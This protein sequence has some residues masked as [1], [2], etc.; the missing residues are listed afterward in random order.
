MLSS[1]TELHEILLLAPEWQ[2]VLDSVAA[3][4]ATGKGAGEVGPFQLLERLGAKAIYLKSQTLGPKRTE[5]SRLLRDHYYQPMITKMFGANQNLKRFWAQRRHPFDWQ[6]GQAVSMAVELSTKMEG[7]LERH[8]TNQSA[9]GF[10]VL[11]PAY[12]QRS[13]QNAVVDYIKDEWQW[14]RETLQDLNLDPEHEDPRSSTAD[15][16]KYAPENLAMSGEQVT[17]LNQLR[18]ELKGMLVGAAGKEREPLVVLD[19]MFGL[20]LTDK[21]SVGEELTMRE[22][23]DLLQIAGETQARKIARCQVLLDK[24]LDMVRQQVRKNLPGVADCWQAD[25]NINTASRRELTHQLGLTEGEVERLLAGRQYYSLSEL[26]ENQV[27]KPAKLDEIARN[28][29]VAAFVPLEVNSCTTR[30]LIDILGFPKEMAQKFAVGRPYTSFDQALRSKNLTETVLAEAIKRGAAIKP[31]S[32]GEKRLDLNS[33]Q[34]ENLTTLGLAGQ[35]VERIMR[36]RPF[37]TWSEL[38]EYLAPDNREW[39]ILRQ[40]TCLGISD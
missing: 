9:D 20:G 11:L 39:L 14:E 37:T 17:Q 1:K 38:E 40:K 32:T 34:G 25:I 23:C 33:T 16:V 3:R 12:V 19:C 4:Q 15:D 26:S 10:K 27:L 6:K 2:S 36:G 24:G 31:P 30:D 28:G 7:V 35:M 22:V 13:V 18:S 5:F 21:S 8:L 29:A